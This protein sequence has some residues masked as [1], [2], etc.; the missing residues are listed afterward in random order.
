VAEAVWEA[1]V[2][3]A[4]VTVLRGHR[5]KETNGVT[6]DGTRIAALRFENGAEV[7][8]RVFIEATHEGDLLAFAGLSFAVGREGNAKY[9][10]TNN[11]IR[12]DTT[13]KQHDKPIDSYVTCPQRPPYDRRLRF[14]RDA[15]PQSQPLARERQ[16]RHDL[17]AAG[18]PQRPLPREGWSRLE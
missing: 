8:A 14:D 3:E 17:V 11:G 1:W 7:R 9:G 13:H 6:K 12:T 15:A 16:R 2:E 5:L 10:E 18:L 4:G